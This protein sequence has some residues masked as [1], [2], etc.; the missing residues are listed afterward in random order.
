MPACGEKTEFNG[1][2]IVSENHLV[3][4]LTHSGPIENQIKNNMGCPLG[5][6]LVH[7]KA[8]FCSSPFKQIRN[9]KVSPAAIQY[10]KGRV[11]ES[12]CD[13]NTP[14]SPA[15]KQATIRIDPRSKI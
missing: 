13:E 7:K 5:A 15:L 3:V 4:G 6:E 11:V 1:V 12:P 8:Q 10:G 14:G 9:D 2:V